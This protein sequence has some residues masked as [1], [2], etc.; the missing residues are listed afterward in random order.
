MG[1]TGI[2]P[3]AHF[4]AWPGRNPESLFTSGLVPARMLRR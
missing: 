3:A 1:L 4:F 2:E